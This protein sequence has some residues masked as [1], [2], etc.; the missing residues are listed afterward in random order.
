MKKDNHTHLFDPDNELM[1][2]VGRGELT[3]FKQ[4][5]E[6][7]QKKVM[8]TIYRYCGNR[9]ETEDVAQEIFFKVYKAAPHYTPRAH[10]TT[11]LY[12]VVVNHCLN[13]LRNQ[14]KDALFASPDTLS[15]GE[16][17]IFSPFP[18]LQGEQPESLLQQQELQEILKKAIGELPERQR[19]ALILHRFEGLSYKE[20]AL[21]LGCSLSA[22]ESLLFRAMISLKEKLKI[23]FT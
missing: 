12:K 2:R 20:I 11:W 15:R 1:K 9:Q 23:Y 14:K 22:V 18:Q 10:F 17:N 16:E 13:Y 3:A 21:V 4:L 5:V 6:K 19:M 8:G 7:Y